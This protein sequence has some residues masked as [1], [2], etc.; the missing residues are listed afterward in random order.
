[1]VLAAGCI[2]RNKEITALKR[3]LA[4]KDVQ[5]AAKDAAGAAKNAKIVVL[6]W[7]L[8]AKHAA[9]AAKDAQQKKHFQSMVEWREG[10]Q[11]YFHKHCELEKEHAKVTLRL[12]EKLNQANVRHARECEIMDEDYRD[13]NGYLQQGLLDLTVQNR[14]MTTEI[15]ALKQQ[16][17]YLNRLRYERKIALEERGYIARALTLETKRRMEY[18]TNGSTDWKTRVGGWQ[19]K[20]GQL[21][22]EF[23]QKEREWLCN[24]QAKSQKFFCLNQMLAFVNQN[25]C[26]ANQDLGTQVVSITTCKQGLETQVQDLST[27]N[28]GLTSQVES[29]TTTNKGINTQVENLTTAIKGRTTQLESLT[30]ANKGLNTQVQDLGTQNQTLISHSQSPSTQDQDPALVAQARLEALKKQQKRTEEATARVNLLQELACMPVAARVD[31]WDSAENLAKELEHAIEL[32][33][34]P[35]LLEYLQM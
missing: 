12:N 9:F 31:F 30:T 24:W 13:K 21:Q 26:T 35:T 20:L 29:L 10:C 15:I 14:S 2:D 17:P 27:T 28:K 1:M 33:T 16:T 3:K 6:K 5:L 34:S 19:Q 32:G 18:E 22:Q 8:A 11:E 4:A 23:E 25:L 7:K